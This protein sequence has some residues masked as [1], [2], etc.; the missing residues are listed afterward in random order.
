MGFMLLLDLT[1]IN[2]VFDILPL[3]YDASLTNNTEYLNRI[4]ESGVHNQFLLTEIYTD[5]IDYI[6]DF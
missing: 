4:A 6:Y 5:Y 1:Q 2:G 3:L